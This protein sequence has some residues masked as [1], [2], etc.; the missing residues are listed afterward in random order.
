MFHFNKNL[1]APCT[2]LRDLPSVARVNNTKTD[3]STGMINL[4]SKSIKK[5]QAIPAKFFLLPN[6]TSKLVLVGNAKP[7]KN[8]MSPISSRV[9]IERPYLLGSSF[10]KRT[11]IVKNLHYRIEKVERKIQLNEIGE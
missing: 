5:I 10:H 1:T 8:I 4:K 3:P 2:L 7:V 9:T 6:N 11:E